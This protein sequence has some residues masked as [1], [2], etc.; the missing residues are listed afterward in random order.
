LVIPVQFII[1]EG[2]RTANIALVC[3]GKVPMLRPLADVNRGERE[4]NPYRVFT[5]LVNR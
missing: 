4:R 2:R 3:W 1:Y 5:E